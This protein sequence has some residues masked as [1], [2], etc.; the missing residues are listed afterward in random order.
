V[1]IA[2]FFMLLFVG[3]T[4]AQVIPGTPFGGVSGGGGGG[5]STTAQNTWTDTQTFGVR[6][7]YPAVNAPAIVFAGDLNTGWGWR[8]ASTLSAFSNNSERLRVGTASVETLGAALI[9]NGNL[10]AFT[11]YTFSTAEALTLN[12]G[13]VT[14]ATAGNL[15]AA[16]S[17]IEAILVRVN[18]TITTAVNFNVRVTGGNPFV[19]I[20]TATSN[21]TGITAGTTH[22]LVPAAVA[23]SYNASATT[24]TVTTNA[25]PGAGV[26][27][28]EV[29]YRTFNPPSS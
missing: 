24:L 11:S 16:A 29:V 2:A 28:L 25:N 10:G 13:G 17:S 18:T 14:T 6:S 4:M 20:G 26:L 22:V 5:A 8:T 27:R 1:L 7:V 15:A 3:R 21:V 23:D 12:T 9:N 19:L